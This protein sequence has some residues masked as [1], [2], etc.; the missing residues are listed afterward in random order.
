MNSPPYHYRDILFLF[1][2][3]W[4]IYLVEVKKKKNMQHVAWERKKFEKISQFRF[5]SIEKCIF[6]WVKFLWMQSRDLKLRISVN[7]YEFTTST[8]LNSLLFANSRY[9]MNI[10]EDTEMEE[11]RLKMFSFYA[12]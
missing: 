2:L 12:N 10:V 5:K 6:V 7:I 11:K 8:G 1:N 4:E 3:K 9:E